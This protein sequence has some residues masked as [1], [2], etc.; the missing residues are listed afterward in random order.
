MHTVSPLQ[1]HNCHCVAAA[2]VPLLEIVSEPDM[3]SAR[4]AAAY[5][6][7]LRR[8]CRFLGISD[9]NM[10]EGS[11]RCDVNISVRPKG[12]AAFGT[13][14]EVKNM[15]SFSNMQKAIEFEIERQVNTTTAW[16]L[17]WGQPLSR[18]V[19]YSR[20]GA[21]VLPLHP[22]AVRRVGCA[23]PVVVG[24]CPAAA[25]PLP[26]LT[27]GAIADAL[28]VLW[29]WLPCR[30]GGSAAIGARLRGCAGDAAVGR[31]Q[32]GDHQ[33]AHEGGAGGLQVCLWVWVC[34]AKALEARI[35]T[36][37]CDGCCAVLC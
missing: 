8:I 20:R 33:H 19:K 30:S 9:G 35:S 27:C 25:P 15:N 29:W 21:R 12:A 17:R 4:D 16:A 11:M 6:A 31:G 37:A 26:V 22:A 13:K 32:A 34:W 2:G 14:V 10:A 18:D 28:P 24:V 23:G 7:E 36:G 5:G 1:R 3:R